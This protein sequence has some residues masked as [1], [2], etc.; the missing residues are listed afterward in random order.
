[1]ILMSP[2]RSSTVLAIPPGLSNI[3]EIKNVPS[4]GYRLRRAFE[5]EECRS[6]GRS[7]DGTISFA[8][9]C[10]WTVSGGNANR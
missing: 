10:E 1:M 2:A 9:E 3:G 7:V 5:R 4:G 6:A 8:G